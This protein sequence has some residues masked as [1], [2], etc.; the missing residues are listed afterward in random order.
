MRLLLRPHAILPVFF[1][2]VSLFPGRVGYDYSLLGEILRRGDSTSWWGASYFWFFKFLTLNGITIA[3]LS[4]VSLIVLAHALIFFVESLPLGIK[5]RRIV[6]FAVL[7]SPL[8]GFFG[9]NVSHDSVGSSGIVLLTAV[10]IRLSRR[11]SLDNGLIRILLLSGIYL[12]TIHLGPV[13]AIVF[14]L[15]ALFYGRHWSALI[16]FLFCVVMI[17]LGKVTISIFTSEVDFLP[18]ESGAFN[19]VLIA[20][21][22]C[23]TQHPQAEI[24]E[25]EWQFLE[26]ISTREVWKTPIS[27]ANPDTVFQM[28]GYADDFSE[29]S[30]LLMHYIKIVSRQP[31]LPLM[32]HIQRSAIALPPPFF[33]PPQNQVSWN[34]ELP[35]GLGTNTAI[36]QG[37]QLL[38]L[39]IDDEQ[40][41]ERFTLTKPLE[42]FAFILGF[43][44]NQASWF[45]SWGGLWLYPLAFGIHRL[46]R[47]RVFEIAVL[48]APTAAL[49]F[50]I[51]AIGT[52][53]LGRYVM[54]TILM[55][56]I[57]FLT[58]IFRVDK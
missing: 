50:L 47:K 39:S 20:D 6:T 54:S 29:T 34:L 25:K 43:T 13:I 30:E 27:C 21:I 57:L 2:Y 18:K 11:Y 53:S 26:R 5:L 38:H 17:F 41:D 16:P 23:I 31:A 9:A 33:Q 15:S 8:F 35:I 56:F 10:L 28:V 51:F 36:Q 32:S 22:K 55:G 42:G 45:W 48:L 4:F 37:P 24:T 1:W 3:F 44:I 58:F 40:F 49:H 7:A 46:L 52:G 19:R 12:S 14:F